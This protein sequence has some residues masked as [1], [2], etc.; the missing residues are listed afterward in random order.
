MRKPRIRP[1]IVLKSFQCTK[2][3][4]SRVRALRDASTAALRRSEVDWR[5]GLRPTAIRR[6]PRLAPLRHRNTHTRAATP[7]THA[8]ADVSTHAVTHTHPRQKLINSI[9]TQHTTVQLH[10]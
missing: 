6:P 2:L 9:K 10:L 4:G 1:K 7:R 3:L 8:H 5:L